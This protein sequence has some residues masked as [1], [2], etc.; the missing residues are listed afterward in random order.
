[1]YMRLAMRENSPVYHIY[2]HINN[3]GSLVASPPLL[4]CWPRLIKDFLWFKRLKKIGLEICFE[5]KQEPVI[6]HV[7]ENNEQVSSNEGDSSMDA[8]NEADSERESDNEELSTPQKH[9]E[10]PTKTTSRKSS[11]KDAEINEETDREEP[12]LL[13]MSKETE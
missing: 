6:N 1:M 9:N 5:I 10:E 4:I 11:I 3:Y 8:G 2:T 12:R 13:D 7:G